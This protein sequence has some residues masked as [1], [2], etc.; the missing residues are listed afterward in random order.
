MK[1]LLLRDIGDGLNLL[2]KNTR[3][4]DLTIDYGGDK[5]IQSGICF[6]GN[7]LLTHF[8]ADHYNG[9][10]DRHKF[11]LCLHLTKCFHPIMP[12][13]TNNRTF[14]MSLLAMNIRISKNHPLQSTILSLIQKLNNQQIQFIPLSKGDTF[15]VGKSKYEVLWP[16]K[17]VNEEDTLKAIRDAIEDFNKA[18]EVDKKLQKIYERISTIFSDRDIFKIADIELDKNEQLENSNQEHIKIIR[19]ANESLK[20][21]ANRLSLAFKQGQNL[22][23]LGD[24]ERS[25]IDLVVNDLI[26]QETTYFEI[27]IASHHGTHW[28]N[29]LNNISTHYCLSST[30]LDMRKHID[31]RYKDIS[32]KFVRTDEWGDILVSNS[33]KIK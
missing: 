19:T 9:F 14:F 22:L 3:N 16:P 4:F 13:F 7:F 12:Q 5:G 6:I 25:E 28:G 18:K 24:L 10:L 29:S 30:G 17:T 8:H 32:E 33:F 1:K 31:Y 15:Q 2:I 27:L 21:A 26:I 23:F 20:K 11:P